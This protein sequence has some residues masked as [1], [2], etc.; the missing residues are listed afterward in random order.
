MKVYNTL[1]PYKELDAE[2]LQYGVCRDF[3]HLSRYRG[4]RQVVHNVATSEQFV[5]LE[6]PNSFRSNLTNCKVH[7]V[8]YSEQNR[9]DVIAD[10]YLGSSSYAWVISYMNHIEDGYTI[11]EGQKLVIP[12]SITDLMQNN[13][14][15]SSI[16]AMQ[17]NLGVE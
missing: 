4:L 15:L 7:T 17:L 8:T 3:D 1:T 10:K 9:L 2:P 13:E 16:P 14:F 5:T 6:T 12:N 11:R